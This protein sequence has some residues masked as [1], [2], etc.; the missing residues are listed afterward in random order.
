VAH[1]QTITAGRW[2]IEAGESR[3]KRL[4]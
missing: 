4:R 3:V 2:E 1:F